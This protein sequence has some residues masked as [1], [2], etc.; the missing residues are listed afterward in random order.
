[1]GNVV[2]LVGMAS[3]YVGLQGCLVVQMGMSGVA[4]MHSIHSGI[5]SA[6]TWVETLGFI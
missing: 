6:L 3:L 2:F 4:N 5:Q 1:M